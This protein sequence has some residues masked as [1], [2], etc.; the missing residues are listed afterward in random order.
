MLRAR[1]LFK[2]RTRQTSLLF[3]LI[4]LCAASAA[5]QTTATFAGRDYPIVGNTHIA[6][7]FNGDGR[8]DLVVT[9]E[10]EQTSLTVLLNNGD[11]TFGAPVGF[12]NVNGFDG[13]SLTLADFDH[14]GRL[15]AV[16]VHQFSCFSAGCAIGDSV[17]F[18]RG[19]GDGSF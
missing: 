6:A 16:V 2:A 5:A 10:S 9:N 15:D 11:G 18:W 1:E 14:D 3:A 17:T 4:L 19:V 13:P 8:P 12:P 7:D